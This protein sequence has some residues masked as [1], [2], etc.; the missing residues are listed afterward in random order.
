MEIKRYLECMYTSKVLKV[1]TLLK[2]PERRRCLHDKRLGYRRAS[3]M[4]KK[5]VVT[6]EQQQPAAAKMLSSSRKLSQNPNLAKKNISYGRRNPEEPRR[7]PENPH[8]WT[9]PVPGLLAGEDLRLH[10]TH[11][12]NPQTSLEAPDLRL[13]F[14]HSGV[15]G[16]TFKPQEL[17]HQPHKPLD[18]RPWRNRLSRPQPPNAN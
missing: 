4:Y 12:E 11:R 16:G 8:A 14:R 1:N 9:L 15:Y 6:L 5:A 3:S 18:L 10:P 7:L 2:V 13:P 17:Q